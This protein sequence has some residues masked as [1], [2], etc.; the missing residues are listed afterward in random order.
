MIEL[1]GSEKQVKWASDI[2]EATMAKLLAAAA[3]CAAKA[4][5]TASD[6]RRERLHGVAADY[7]TISAAVQGL[8][9]ATDWIDARGHIGILARDAGVDLPKS[10]TDYLN[11]AL[12][13]LAERA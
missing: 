5:A 13:A 9:S 1:I 7:A 12:A 2:R 8:T 10:R 11:E 6:D 4:Q 3:N